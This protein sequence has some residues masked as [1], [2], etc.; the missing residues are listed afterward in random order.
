MNHPLAMVRWH[1]DTNVDCYLWEA[2]YDEE[3][4]F[5]AKDDKVMLRLIAFRALVWQILYSVPKQQHLEGLVRYNLLYRWFSGKQY[6][7]FEP[8]S[9]AEIEEDLES[10]QPEDSIGNLLAGV[11]EMAEAGA[12]PDKH[13]FTP[14]HALLARWCARH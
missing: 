7:L 3:D 14:D 11:I 6:L 2:F 1:I 4:E 10:I 9:F 13:G 12:P 5:A 8:P